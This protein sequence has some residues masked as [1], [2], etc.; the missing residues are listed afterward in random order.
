MKQRSQP[1]RTLLALALITTAGG[2]WAQSAGSWVGK[3]GV[4]RSVP[5]VDSG[6]LTP[7]PVPNARIDMSA[8]TSLAL[9]ASYFFTDNLS[10]E[11]WPGLPVRYDIVGRGSLAGAGKIASTRPIAPTV[12]GQWHFGAAEARFRPYA[13][14]GVTYIHFFDSQGT[15]T[16][17][18]LTAPPGGPKTKV[19]IDSAWG[20]SP[21]LGVKMKV[22]DR[23]RVDFSLVKIYVKTTTHLSTGQ[24]IDYRIDPLVI[25]LTAGYRF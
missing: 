5:D 7:S 16:L 3:I 10:V 25:I 9:S 13:G 6:S 23:W 22:D 8:V 20:V 2:V 19:S 14:L 18:A 11:A 4:Y 15:D 21:Q 1:A 17:T 24:S 12:L